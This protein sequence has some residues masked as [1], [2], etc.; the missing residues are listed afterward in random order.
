MPFVRTGLGEDLYAAK[1]RAIILGGKWILIDADFANGG[2]WRQGSVGEAIDINLSSVWPH[3]GSGKR[4]QILLQF[5]RIVGERFEVRALE[6][7][8]AG[9]V[10]RIDID[11][12]GVALDGDL[13]LFDRD[14]ERDIELLRLSGGDDDIGHLV[15]GEARGGGVDRNSTRRQAMNDVVAKLI[16]DRLLNLAVGR[17]H[18]DRGANHDGARGICNLARADCLKFSEPVPTSSSQK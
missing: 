6:N 1:A 3:G 4:E 7:R 8:G 2:L 5:V 13:L 17:G 12:C 10:R 14:A 16:A 15:R 11:G 9:I 18:G